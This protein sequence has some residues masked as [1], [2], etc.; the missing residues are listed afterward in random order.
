MPS[1]DFA[2]WV[3]WQGSLFQGMP[4]AE[5]FSWVQ[6]E[7][8]EQ[9]LAPMLELISETCSHAASKVA[10]L[11]NLI[12]ELDNVAEG[13]PEPY[14]YAGSQEAMNK[15]FKH[16]PCCLML[17]VRRFK[18]E[19]DQAIIRNWWVQLNHELASRRLPTCGVEVDFRQRF[20]DGSEDESTQDYSVYLLG[21]VDAAEE[22]SSS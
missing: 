6:D 2:F 18:R 11:Q 1:T 20:P 16:H 13:A 15:Q 7:V 8:F 9:P 19:T 21:A 4:W 22:P 10:A 17:Q 14:E 5:D 3:P 12:P